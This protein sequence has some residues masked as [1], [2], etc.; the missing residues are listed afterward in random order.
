MELTIKNYPISYNRMIPIA[1]FFQLT[2]QNVSS[3]EYIAPPS[4]TK[5]VLIVTINH[6]TMFQISY[7][8]LGYH[9][10]SKAC[11]YSTCKRKWGTV[12]FL[13]IV[14]QYNI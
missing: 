3:K 14:S 12:P 7:S 10:N 11:V 6:A 1:R 13:L 5:T 9:F 2:R 8:L 4:F